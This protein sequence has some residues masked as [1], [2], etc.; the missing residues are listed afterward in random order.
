MA[1]MLGRVSPPWCRIRKAPPR[2]DCPEEGKT[3]GQIRLAERRHWRREFLP[4]LAGRWPEIR[5][6]P[7]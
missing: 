5:N 6:D 4:A 3:K 7:R 2:P 1:R